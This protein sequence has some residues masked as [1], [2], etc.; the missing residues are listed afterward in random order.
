M[1]ET[2]KKKKKT[3]IGSAPK[4]LHG[5]STQATMLTSSCKRVFNTVHSSVRLPQHKQTNKLSQQ[6]HL[7]RAV[8]A[9]TGL[10]SAPSKLRHCSSYLVK[11]VHSVPEKEDMINTNWYMINNKKWPRY[12]GFY[13]LDEAIAQR[14]DE[15]DLHW[16]RDYEADAEEYLKERAQLGTLHG[17]LLTKAVQQATFCCGG[18]I[19]L[20]EQTE[21][22]CSSNNNHVTTSNTNKNS[23]S[24]CSVKQVKLFFDTNAVSGTV[25]FPPISKEQLQKLVSACSPATFGCV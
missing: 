15:E 11:R 8:T 14:T 1:P 6:L 19:A 10:R 2:F 4:P 25:T 23:N 17:K 9:A 22:N 5:R 24:I 12:E 21:A 18:S 16:G 20:T 13:R 3:T 7:A